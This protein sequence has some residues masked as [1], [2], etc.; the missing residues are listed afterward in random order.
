MATIEAKAISALCVNKDIHTV[1]GEESEIFGA[2]QDIFED[3]R[4]YYYRYKSVPGPELVQEMHPDVELPE[5]TGETSYYVNELKNEFL[6]S[7]MQAIIFKTSEALKENAPAKVLEKIQTELARLG[8]FATAAIDLDLTNAEEAERHFEKIRQDSIDNGGTPGISTGISS[9]DSAYTTGMAPGH[10]IVPMGYTSR[11]KSLFTAL[12]AVKAWEQGYKPMIVSLEMSPE[13]QRER[14]YA[15]MSSGLFKTSD[16]S[17][18]DISI[19]DFRA[20]SSKNLEDRNGFIVVSNKGHS[21]ITPNVIQA[22]ID[23][24]KPDIVICD[25]MQLMMDNAKTQA[26]TPRMLNLSRELKLLAVSNNIPVVAITA[27]TDED[28]DKR[29][30]PPMLSQIAWSSGIEYDANLAF[31]V[32]RHDDTNTVEIAGRKNRNGDLFN[33]LFTVNFDRGIWEESF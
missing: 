3:I 23:V 28:G 30:A 10:L 22:K 33:C 18:G 15:M 21:V 1:L 32:H 4:G 6:E 17:R 9:I 19:D 12:L 20:W 25:Y 5:V 26:M 31:A 27:V 11:G 7:R 8:R 14:V 24:H 29:D 2:Y 16:L 13:E